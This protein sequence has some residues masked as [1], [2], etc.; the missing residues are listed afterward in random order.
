MGFVQDVPV[1]RPK[2]RKLGMVKVDSMP[3]GVTGDSNVDY[4]PFQ[5][6]GTCCVE[7]S[8]VFLLIRFSGVVYSLCLLNVAN[9]N[10]LIKYS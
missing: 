5:V 8:L 10:M 4:I 3:H 2:L 1:I 9:Y 7:F 6:R